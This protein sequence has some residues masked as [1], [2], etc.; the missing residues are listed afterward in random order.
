[1]DGDIQ[2]IM[3]ERPAAI[4]FDMD[5]T[6]VA[7][8]ALWR[9]AEERLL[10]AMG[11]KWSADLAR[12]Y[13]GMNALDVAATIHRAVQPEMSVRECQQLMRSALIAEFQQIPVRS[14][15]GAA[16][17]VRRM[18]RMAPLALASGSPPEAIHLAL[19]QLGLYREFEVVI[20]S[21]TV[22]RGKPHPDVFLAA[23]K[24]MGA[25][26]EHCL[27]IEDSLIGV[28]AAKAAEMRCFAVPSGCREEIEALETWVFDSLE[29]ITE[30]TVLAAQAASPPG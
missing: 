23:A 17:C 18:K 14:M 16:E 9:K 19:V 26:A 5:D 24:A 12:Q 4:I 6:L 29:E 3:V 13:K 8:R 15:P 11:R 1:M 25:S 21:E 7:T 20:S 28:R 22:A 2:M 27:V 10:A 30:S